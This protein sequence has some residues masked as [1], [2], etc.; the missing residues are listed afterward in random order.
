MN[1]SSSALLT[2]VRVQ[3]KGLTGFRFQDFIVQFLFKVHTPEG[4]TDMRPQRDKGCDG[5]I[6]RQKVIVA[7][8]APE[9][10]GKRKYKAKL[11]DDHKKY[12]ANYQK[13]Y[14][15]WRP[16][17]NRAPTPDDINLVRGFGLHAEEPWGPERIIEAISD[18]AWP[19][20]ISLYKWLGVEK[21][22]IGQDYIRFILDDLLHDR[23]R[24]ANVVA[25]EAAPNIPEK[26]DL[27]V[28]VEY[29]QEFDRFLQ[30][31]ALTQADVQDILSAFYN[32]ELETIK[33]RINR[34]FGDTVG[35]GDFMIRFRQ[36]QQRFYD[37]YND[38][39]DD[40]AARNIDAVLAYMFCICQIGDDPK[41]TDK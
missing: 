41:K 39:D 17:L 25:R 24:A 35:R 28:P 1:H 32:N 23:Q 34:E 36:L 2:S 15:T 10:Y 37:R 11:E 14:P 7:C 31:T 30:S 19:L 22:L 12:V 5:I 26:I 33:S 3:I 6:T 38:G 20:R 29:R 21:E 40:V 9:E 13:D 16:Y 27:N 4:F 18:L 8:Y